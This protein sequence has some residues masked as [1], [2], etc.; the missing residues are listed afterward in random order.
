MKQQKERFS[1]EN[2]GFFIDLLMI[3]LGVFGTV[4]GLAYSL[5]LPEQG[6]YGVYILIVVGMLLYM[7]QYLKKAIFK[8]FVIMILMISAMVVFLYS[9]E[10]MSLLSQLMTVIENDYFLRF[11]E[12]F[13]NTHSQDS[14][15]PTVLMIFLGLPITHYVVKVVSK[16]KQKLFPFFVFIIIFV[17]PVFIQHNL[18]IHTSYCFMLF[19]AYEYIFSYALQKQRNPIKLKIIVLPL[20]AFLLFLSS[21]FLEPNP[22]FDQSTSTVLSQITS[23]INGDVL[24]GL[25]N[26][27]HVTGTSSSISG[28]L[29]TSDVSMGH[30]KALTVKATRPFSSYIR[31]YSLAR[32]EN[33]Q[34]EPVNNEFK[35][36]YNSSSLIIQHFSELGIS[37]SRQDVT[38]SSVKKT[39]YQFV[40]YFPNFNKPLINDSYYEPI[41]RS[42]SIYQVYPLI[43]H[44][45]YNIGPVYQRSEYDQYV[46]QEYLDVPSDLKERLTQ[47]LKDNQDDLDLFANGPSALKDPYKADVIQKILTSHASYDLKAGVLPSDKDFVEY[48]MFENK[49]GSCTHFSTSLALLLRCVGIPTRFTRGYILKATDFVDGEATVFSNRSHAW[50][51]AYFEG[52]GWVPYEA[53]PVSGS[54]ATPTDV[55]TMLDDQLE[56]DTNPS[57][58]ETQEQPTDQPDANDSDTDDSHP[59]TPTNTTHWYDSIVD[60]SYYII[61]A[62]GTFLVLWSYRFVAKRLF[63]YKADKLSSNQKVIY[64]YQRM[65]RMLRFGGKIDDEMIRIAQKA[66]FSQHILT[67]EEVKYVTDYYLIFTTDIYSCLSWHRKLLYKY[68]FGYI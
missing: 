22:I 20:L 27:S 54:T 24:D 38:V 43:S 55:G 3:G 44:A 9:A 51:E 65:K 12:F 21:L 47:F 6:V 29:P 56:Q 34:W 59:T 19:I 16:K 4:G 14:L 7:G 25:F 57:P 5:Y 41:D 66:K 32:Y 35:N 10:I 31:G 42:V 52:Y 40:P 61:S 2:L 15:L 8:Y 53:T 60:Y 46:K 58:N 37:T 28:D 50:V 36:N 68:V 23:W 18:N 64:Y 17:F 49:R 39:S 30:A 13:I 33:N 63:Y 45:M 26:G 67:E 48:F 11:D 1:L 62:L